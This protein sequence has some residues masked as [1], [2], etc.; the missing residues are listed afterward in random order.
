[1]FTA[2]HYILQSTEQVL[3]SFTVQGV[4]SKIPQGQPDRP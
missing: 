3:E 2:M 1:M 4:K